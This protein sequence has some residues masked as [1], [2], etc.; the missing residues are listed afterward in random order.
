[1]VQT[2]RLRMGWLMAETR[3]GRGEMCCRAA[4]C[5]GC[6]EIISRQ[7]S[8]AT[9]MACP[10]LRSMELATPGTEK[11]PQSHP[12]PFCNHRALQGQRPF[13]Q[14]IKP[15]W[16]QQRGGE[17]SMTAGHRGAVGLSLSPPAP[18]GSQGVSFLAEPLHSPSAWRRSFWESGAFEESLGNADSAEGWA[19]PG[20][21]QGSSR[22]PH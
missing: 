5:T 16:E 11:V 7:Q 3:A 15:E 14:Q 8:G 20:T 17:D 12:V 10:H 2:R 21:G 19:A 9:L 6:L 1:M 13:V 18:T 22:R 4:T